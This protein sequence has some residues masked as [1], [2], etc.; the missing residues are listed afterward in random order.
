MPASDIGDDKHSKTAEG[1]YI[2][3]VVVHSPAPLNYCIF[4]ASAC[5]GLLIGIHQHTRDMKLQ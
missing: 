3:I 5:S 1:R 2:A 4:N